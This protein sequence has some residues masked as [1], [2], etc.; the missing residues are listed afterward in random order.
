MS[1]QPED[2]EFGE[3]TSSNTRMKSALHTEAAEYVF[4]LTFRS[5]Y[6]KSIFLWD[7]TLRSVVPVLQTA[8][9]RIP[10]DR[11]FGALRIPNH[12][13]FRTEIFAV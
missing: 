6:N 1:C 3:G 9:P 4:F 10:D 7:V 12:D 13:I 11:N 5:N 2:R 8:Q